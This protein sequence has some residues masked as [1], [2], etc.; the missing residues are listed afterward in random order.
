MRIKTLRSII[1]NQNIRK[2]VIAVV[3]GSGQVAKSASQSGADIILALNAGLYRTYGAGSL[4]SFMPYGNANEQT[5]E[6][7]K[8]QIIPNVKDIPIVAGIFGNDVAIKSCLIRFIKLGVEGVTNWP[9]IGIID[10][11]FRKILETEKMGIQSEIRVLQ[12]AK[13]L[14]LSTFGF[15]CCEEDT[16]KF[17]ESGVDSHIICVGLTRDYPDPY[18]RRDKIQLA[19][20]KAKKMLSVAKKSNNT[21]CFFYGGPIT[22]PEDLKVVLQYLD[23][24]GFAGG[25][26][27]ERVPISETVNSTISKVKGII[28]SS[29]TNTSG[30]SFGKLVGDSKCMQDMFKLIKKVALF[31]V[32]TLINGET[33]TGKE[34]IA[35]QI[36]AISHRQ[37]QP[38]IAMNCGAIPDTLIESELFGYEKGAFT[39]ALSRRKGKFE[40]ANHG[41]LFLDEVGDLSPRAQVALLRVIQQKEITPLAADR[42]IPVDV[43]ILAATH[44]NLH[45]L[46]GRGLFREDI[47]FRLNNIE[48]EVPPLRERLEDIPSLVEYNLRR[49]DKE[50]NRKIIGLT[51]DFYDRLFQHHWPGNVRELEH[52]IMR[53]AILEDSPVLEG[54]SFGLCNKISEEKNII[55]FENKKYQNSKKELAEDIINKVNGNKSEAA[56]LLGISRKTLYQWLNK[57]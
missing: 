8:F 29:R 53:A 22:H 6:L 44:Q 56:K 33:G 23:I 14:G 4:A 39:G 17:A 25:S 20:H 28:S 32:N 13:E 26:I 19:V 16:F 52:V 54:K 15:S 40:L 55:Y 3:A 34:L 42:P 57:S 2:P 11:N 41:T 51:A 9:A 31:D 38:F 21:F 43:R 1:H 46:I 36:H 10:G 7:L 12:E 48:I 5:E 30:R 35:S 24:D 50:L 45:E 27:F 49:F 37:D 18:E 47:Y